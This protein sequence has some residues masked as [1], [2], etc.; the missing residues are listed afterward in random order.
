MNITF[1][2]LITDLEVILSLQYLAVGL[3]SKPLHRVKII[4]YTDYITTTLSYIF[5][6]YWL[7]KIQKPIKFKYD[8]LN[9]KKRFFSGNANGFSYL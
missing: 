4:I 8:N 9:I 1:Y 3:R 5:C 7:H 6:H 2:S